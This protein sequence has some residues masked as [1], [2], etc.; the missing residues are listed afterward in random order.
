MIYVTH[1]QVEAMTLADRIV[2]MR[3]GRVEQVG[4]PMDLYER[5]RTFRRRFHR[6][7]EDE[8]PARPAGASSTPRAGWR[9]RWAT[10]RLVCAPCETHQV[11][12][13]H[14]GLTLRRAPRAPVGGAPGRGPP[15]GSWWWWSSALAAKPTF[16]CAWPSR[17]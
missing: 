14:A 6:L 1:D 11:E 2:V 13:R 7:P 3:D 16:M 8:L 4:A 17:C 10:V 5:R 15:A 9:F 12:A